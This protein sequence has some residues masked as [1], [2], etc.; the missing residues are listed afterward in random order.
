MALG[1]LQKCLDHLGSCVSRNAELPGKWVA[2][3]RKQAEL[4]WVLREKKRRARHL[5][6]GQE[7]AG[8]GKHMDGETPTVTSRPWVSFPEVSAP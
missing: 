5:L 3:R 6:G 7:A 2:F 4:T 1:S 8:R